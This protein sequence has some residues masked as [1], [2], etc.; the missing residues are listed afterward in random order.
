VLKCF[1]A[2]ALKKRK[3]RIISWDRGSGKM[4]VGIAGVVCVLILKSVLLLSLLSLHCRK[5]FRV[6]GWC[7]VVRR[8]GDGGKTCETLLW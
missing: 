1:A 3:K 4:V 8:K 5:K 7:H 2:Q 6:L